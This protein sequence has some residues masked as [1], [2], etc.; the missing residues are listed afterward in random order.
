MPL[1]VRGLV[2]GLP[3]APKRLFA[4]EETK[5]RLERRETAAGSGICD[6]GFT[7]SDA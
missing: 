2:L 3:G 1:G 7:A 6:C 4:S 5:I